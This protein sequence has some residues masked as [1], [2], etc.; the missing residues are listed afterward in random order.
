MGCSDLS[1]VDDRDSN[2]VCERCCM[3]GGRCDHCTHG[4]YVTQSDHCNHESY[5]SQIDHGGL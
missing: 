4:C 5:V 3:L 1:G 2:V